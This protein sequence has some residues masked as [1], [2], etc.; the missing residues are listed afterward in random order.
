[1]SAAPAIWDNRIVGYGTEA[2]DQLLANPLNWRTHPAFQQDALTGVLTSVGVVQNVIVNRVTN[3]L[4]DGHLRV[5]L[6]LRSHQPSIPVTYVELTE[7][8]ERLI[9]STLDPLG[10]LAGQDAALLTGLLAEVQTGDAAV[11]ALL[12]GLAGTPIDPA[13]LWQ[14][15]PEFENEAQAARSLHVH[16]LTEADCARFCELLGLRIT[17]HTKTVWYPAAP[18]R[19][20][21][22]FESDES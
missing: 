14:G 2:P 7:E 15:M 19:D 12:D 9:L 13:A 17:D 21:Y 16:F 18:V 1:V 3:R 22:L 10:A 11:Q 8:E 6:A 5:T 4:I 20:K